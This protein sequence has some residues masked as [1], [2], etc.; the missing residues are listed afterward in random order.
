MSNELTTITSAKDIVFSP[1]AMQQLNQVAG[2]MV[3]IFSM[4]FI[5]LTLIS[6]MIN[7]PVPLNTSPAKAIR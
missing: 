1:S 5:S 6:S 2:L 7:L 3:L 4:S